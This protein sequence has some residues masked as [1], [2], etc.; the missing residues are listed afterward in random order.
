MDEKI[1]LAKGWTFAEETVY[2][3]N[4]DTAQIP[5]WHDE[6]GTARELPDWSGDLNKAAELL[7]EMNASLEC[8]CNCMSVFTRLGRETTEIGNTVQTIRLAICEAYLV[9]KGAR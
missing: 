8:D 2:I 3:F 4:K 6:K 7:I 5:T 9:W 1:A